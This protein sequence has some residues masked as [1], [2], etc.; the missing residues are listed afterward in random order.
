MSTITAAQ[1]QTFLDTTFDAEF[2]SPAWNANW[3]TASDQTMR[4]RISTTE[5]VDTSVSAN[6]PAFRKLAMAYTMLSDLGTRT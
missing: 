3:S 6:E 5:I 1:M 2:A 4:S